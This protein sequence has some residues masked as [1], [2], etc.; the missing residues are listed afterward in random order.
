VIFRG[1]VRLDAGRS[2]VFSPECIIWIVSIRQVSLLPSAWLN[3][4]PDHSRDVYR[5]AAR[6]HE[7]AVAGLRFARRVRELVECSSLL[8]TW[9]S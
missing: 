2:G 6:S 8:A 9:R 7:I 3:R 4:P 1:L 5:I